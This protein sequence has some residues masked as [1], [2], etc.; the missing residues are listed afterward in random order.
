MLPAQKDVGIIT[1]KSES[2]LYN[3]QDK[4][5]EEI[6]NIPKFFNAEKIEKSQLMQQS[7]NQKQHVLLFVQ[8]FLNRKK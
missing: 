1:F 6:K 4:C 2:F 7:Q 5:S 3:L 8:K